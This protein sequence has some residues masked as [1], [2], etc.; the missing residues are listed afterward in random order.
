MIT[1]R[2]NSTLLTMTSWLAVISFILALTPASFAKKKKKEEAPAAP[3]KSEE[4]DHSQI[5]TSK[6]VW[7]QPPDLP[8]IRYVKEIFGEAPKPA[9]GKKKKKQTWMDRMAGVQQ[10]GDTRNPL[11]V[12]HILVRPYGIVEDSKGRVYVA[13]NYVAAIFIVN[14]ENPTQVEFIRNGHEAKFKAIVG[15]AIDDNDRLFVTDANF[16][17][18][19][20]SMPPGRSRQYSG[21][22]S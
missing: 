2:S 7:P 4:V 11:D 19:R 14:P 22:I 15:L 8:R 1:K 21:T 17:G 5:D 9:E 6:L 16:A 20:C 12:R 18:S 13:D 10:E 3:I